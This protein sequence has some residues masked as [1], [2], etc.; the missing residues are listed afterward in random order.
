MA[1]YLLRLSK[2]GTPPI[3]SFQMFVFIDPPKK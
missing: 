2:K 3:I 1:N